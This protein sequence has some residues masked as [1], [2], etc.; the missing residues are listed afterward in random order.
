[1]AKKTED[2]H[3]GKIL[4]RLPKDK[5][6][7]EDVPVSINGKT[8]LIKRGVNVWVSPEVK[9]VL[10]HTEDMEMK[11]FE[12]IEKAVSSFEEESKTV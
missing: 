6:H 7:Y 1:M 12:R 2:P 5:H 11:A 3:K 4:I 9:E 8:T 10:E